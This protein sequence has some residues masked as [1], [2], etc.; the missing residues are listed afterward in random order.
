YTPA[1]PVFVTR[2][3]DREPQV[4]SSWP[5]GLNPTSDEASWWLWGLLGA[6]RD[7]PQ[8]WGVANADMQ[9]FSLWIRSG[10]NHRPT[11]TRGWGATIPASDLIDLMA[12]GGKRQIYGETYLVVPQTFR[13]RITGSQGNYRI[14]FGGTP[15]VEY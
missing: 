12:P 2:Y 6:E 5:P 13:P 15:Y 14:E 3:P 9:A 4:R 8:T 7:N 1:T 10:P 11:H